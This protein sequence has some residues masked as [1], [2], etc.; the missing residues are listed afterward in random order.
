MVEQVAINGTLYNVTASLTV[1][2]QESKGFDKSAALMRE[3]GQLRD[4]VIQRPNG[5]KSWLAAEY[6]TA[7]GSYYR[8]VSSMGGR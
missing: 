2:E 6:A 8:I 3:H 4:L 1:Q 7:D 5:R